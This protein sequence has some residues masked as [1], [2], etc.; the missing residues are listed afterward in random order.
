MQGTW[1]RRRP[2][3]MWHHAMSVKRLTAR[4]GLDELRPPR[5]RQ[6]AKTLRMENNDG[7]TAPTCVVCALRHGSGIYDLE[8]L[9]VFFFFFFLP[10]GVFVVSQTS[11]IN[12]S[13]PGLT[14]Y[15]QFCKWLVC[16]WSVDSLTTILKTFNSIWSQMMVFVYMVLN[17]YSDVT[18]L[19]GS[20]ILLEQSF[21]F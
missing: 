12:F 6:R 18:L 9:R 7:L 8:W 2:S 1:W 10:V 5:A 17:E 16:L 21:F 4:R 20:L 14:T 11:K 19:F 15:S 13:R 3:L